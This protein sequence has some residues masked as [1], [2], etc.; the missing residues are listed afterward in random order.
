MGSAG[1]ILAGCWSVGIAVSAL[2]ALPPL[3]TALS[4]AVSL[5]AAGLTPSAR[6]RLLALG[7]SAGLLGVAWAS[8][9]A[10]APSD[11]PL[12]AY[13]G[14]VV[15]RARLLD[16]PTPRGSRFEVVAQVETISRAPEPRE[17]RQPVSGPARV[18]LRAS[19]IPASHDDL[20][21]LRGQ[22]ARPRSR[23]GWPLAEILARRGIGWTLDAG[24]VRVVEEGRPG[25]RRWLGEARAL[26]EGTA[27][28]QLPEPQASL[29]AGMVFGARAGLPP[30]LRAAM[31]ATSTSHL[32]AVS[33]A[34]VAMVAGALLVLALTV[35]GR[36]PACGLALVGVWLY[37][38][39][40]GAPPSA[41]RAAAM[42]TFALTAQALGRQPDTFAALLVATALLL[43]WDPGLAFDLG[44]QLS[45]AATAGLIVLSPSIQRRLEAVRVPSPVSGWIAVA[46]AAQVATL[47]LV[48]GTFQRVS[49][50]GLPANVLAAPLVPPIMVVGALLALLGGL[51]G[52]DVA[53]GW[54]GWA[55]TSLLL[56]LIVGFAGLPGGTIAVG[57]APVWLPLFWYGALAAWAAG[58]SADLRALG[59]RPAVMWSGL[60]AAALALAA[61]SLAGL[62]VGGR[63]GSTVAAI[64]DVEPSAAVIRAPD[65][66]TTLVMTGQ[67][68]PDVVAG[69]GSQ[70]DLWEHRL[71][72]VVGPGGLRLAVDLLTAGAVADVWPAGDRWSAT[73]TPLAPGTTVDLA[74]GVRVLVVDVRTAGEQPALDLLI[75]LDGLELALPG[76]GAPSDRWAGALS[77]APLAARLP[78]S[79]ASWARSLPPQAWLLLIGDPGTARARGEAGVPLLLARDFGTVELTIHD[80]GIGAR[81]ERCPSGQ[82]CD[83][84][85]PPPQFGPLLL[86]AE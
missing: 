68:G 44:F 55:L 25:L 54:L 20:V 32:T 2:V 13:A 17:A 15:V 53:L 11:D 6:I 23:P 82:S 39:M 8:W 84:L 12:T 34:N 49:L 50:V 16:A 3:L 14:A 48:V 72:V 66:R 27:R 59:L 69:V 80:G 18:L 9:W 58:G 1:L 4:A 73:A 63:D 33:G 86:S 36:A 57:Q 28:E 77:G 42:A 83:L 30:D 45:V 67:S 52:V 78:R 47:P 5:C 19:T 75:Q 46:V 31:S 70:L 56:G 74:D 71:D 76:P 35:V 60:L 24:I 65:G 7:L 38:L 37:A 51:P 85:L 29:L 43:G 61:L 22:L 79:G 26:A 41:L 64:L 21:E 81:T 40:V 10:A 62:A